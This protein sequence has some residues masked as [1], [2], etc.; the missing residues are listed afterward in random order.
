MKLGGVATGWETGHVPPTNSAAHYI[1]LLQKHEASAV[2]FLENV[3]WESADGYYVRDVD[4]NTYI[5]F[6]SGA[7]ITNSGHNNQ[8]IIAAVVE[9]LRSGIYSTYLF[10]NKP[11]ALLHEVLSTISPAGYQSILLNTG[12]EGIE[13]AL[14]I[15]RIHATKTLRNRGLVVSFQNS[16]HGKTLA[17][18]SIGGT[19]ALKYWISDR[20]QS[21]LSAQVPFPDCEYEERQYSFH[22]TLEHL[23]GQGIDIDDVAAF[24]IEPYQGGSCSFVPASYARD[25][26]DFCR[27]RRILVICDEVQSGVGRTGRM[28]AFE[29]LGVVP[30]VFIAGKGLA[31]SLPLSCVIARKD[32]LDL[33]EPG[34]FNTTHSGNP[35]C[36]AA[37]IANINFVLENDIV[38][39]AESVGDLLKARL[40]AIQTKYPEI[41]AHVL[42]RGLAVSIHIDQKYKPILHDLL[43][44]FIR[45]GLLVVNPGGVGGTTFKLVPPLIIDEEG[46]SKACEIIDRSIAETVSSLTAVA[47]HPVR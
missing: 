40:T 36:C 46:I 33:C 1:S 31:A 14:K 37:A 20:I 26:V 27:E 12:S 25:L 6:S 47:K 11:R 29:H 39:R 3:V 18:T 22:D 4:G 35:I 38:E 28:W 13:T 43:T 24:F 41:V 17:S 16:F 5:D 30:D 10:P 19:D 21:E 8:A 44:T 15:A 2:R 23:E 45:N 9:Q 7:M 32:L 42:G 34:S